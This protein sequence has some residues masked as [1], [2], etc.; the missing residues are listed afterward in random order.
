MTKLELVAF[1]A[2][3]I[4]A[5][6]QRVRLGLAIGPEEFPSRI[7][8]VEQVAFNMLLALQESVDLGSHIVT[9]E[10]WGTPASLGDTFTFLHQHG[11]IALDT[12]EAM[13]VGTRL[14]NLIA[15]AYGDVDPGKLFSAASAGVRQIERFLAETGA[16][17]TA[18]V[19]SG[20]PG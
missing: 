9:D 3:R 2:S 20:S 5:R 6:L 11:V 18:H 13:R 4:Q 7:D 12:A 15:H 1:K 19:G 14:R 10:G 16:W 17:V 8:L